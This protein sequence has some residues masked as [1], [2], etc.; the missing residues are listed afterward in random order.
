MFESTV[1]MYIKVRFSSRFHFIEFEINS[2]SE[3]GEIFT[4]GV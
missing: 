4:F 1:E 2:F 3:I